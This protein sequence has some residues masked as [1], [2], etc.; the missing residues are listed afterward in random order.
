MG[1]VTG[2]GFYQPLRGVPMSKAFASTLDITFEVRGGLFTRQIHHWAALM[3]VAAIMV[4][5]ARIFFTGAFR[6]RHEAQLG[7]RLTAA[8]PGDV[9]GILRLLAAG[10]PAVGPRAACG[11][12]LDHAGAFR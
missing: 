7:H 4:H 1:D 8:D 5:L 2:R 12:V 6:R 11:A 3:F 9:R 10:R